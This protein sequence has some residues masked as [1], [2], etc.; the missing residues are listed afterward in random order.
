MQLAENS[1]E[2]APYIDTLNTLPEPGALIGCRIL[3]PRLS[4]KPGGS[5]VVCKRGEKIWS[6]GKNELERIIF[7]TPMSEE[8]FRE[9]HLEVLLYDYSNPE[10]SI[11]CMGQTVISMHKYRLCDATSSNMVEFAVKEA[12]YWGGVRQGTISGLGYISSSRIQ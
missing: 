10:R 12:Y 3:G 4:V 1:E 9:Q 11:P 2:Q 5:P 7:L 8:V 6:F